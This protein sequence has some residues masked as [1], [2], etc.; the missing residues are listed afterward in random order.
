MVSH[1]DPDHYNQL[2]SVL[3]DVTARSVWQGGNPAHYTSAN[4]S[5]WLEGQEKRGAQVHRNFAPDFHN[6]R[7]PVSDALSCGR[8][9]TF[10]LTANTGASD[11]AQSL[12]LMIEHEDFTVVFTGDAEGA[13]E[14]QALTN[15]VNAVKATVITSSHHGASTF[16]SNSQG[17]ADGMAPEVLISSAGNRFFHPR[18]AATDR[19][20]SL[21][22]TKRHAVR[23]GSSTAYTA[24]RTNRA[25]YVTEVNG[26][27]I[28]TSS[29]KSPLTVNCTRSVECGGTIGH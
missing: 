16:A 25:H 5:T 24:S 12:V 10:V 3:D 27:I 17:W 22:T 7:Q 15:Y 23:C 18:C 19:F 21:A 28:I 14:A 1:A 4:F 29:G 11:N 9:S 6:Q 20:T 26:A 13:T 8:A 2:P